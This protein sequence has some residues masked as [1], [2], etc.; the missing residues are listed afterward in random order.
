MNGRWIVLAGVLAGCAAHDGVAN[1]D[2]PLLSVETRLAC[3]V[4]TGPA[5]TATRGPRRNYD[6]EAM[7]S[8]PAPA[9]VEAAVVGAVPRR[10][11]D[12][13]ERIAA[14]MLAMPEVTVAVDATGA[15]ALVE[16]AASAD[17]R[18]AAP[19]PLRLTAALLPTSNRAAEA[20]RLAQAVAVRPRPPR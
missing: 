12:P 4:D 13:G 10:S 16:P 8:V 5:E 11:C 6:G 9:S 15:V 14:L 7:P 18:P 2:R 19:P 17:A 3:A 1:V 20:M